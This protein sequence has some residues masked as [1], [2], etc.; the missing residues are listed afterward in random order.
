[1]HPLGQKMVNG[2]GAKRTGAAWDYLIG[3][4][5]EEILQSMPAAM[6]TFHFVV[7]KLARNY[8]VCLRTVDKLGDGQHRICGP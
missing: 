2:N 1:M 6:D 3:E 5:Y 8:S 7:Y 4:I